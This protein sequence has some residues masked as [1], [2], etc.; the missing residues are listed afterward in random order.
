MV[1]EGQLTV[2]SVLLEENREIKVKCG[3]LEGQVLA[4]Q[5]EIRKL[6]LMLVKKIEQLDEMHSK[7]PV[8]HRVE[9]DESPK[10]EKQDQGVETVKTPSPNF[11][12]EAT[13]VKN[14]A[15][16]VG[17]VAQSKQLKSENETQKFK[18]ESELQSVRAKQAH[19]TKQQHQRS[20]VKSSTKSSVVSVK[21]E[22]SSFE[23]TRGSYQAPS[24]PQVQESQQMRGSLKAEA[25]I[26]KQSTDRKSN[27][28]D[29]VENEIGQEI[30]SR[31]EIIESNQE[32][33][34]SK[35]EVIGQPPINSLTDIKSTVL[36]TD[37]KQI[38]TKSCIVLDLMGEEEEASPTS[39]I[40]AF[41]E[42]TGLTKSDLASYLGSQ[43]PKAVSL[44]EKESHSGFALSINSTLQPKNLTAQSKS[45]SFSNQSVSAAVKNL[46]SQPFSI[47][48]KDRIAF[49]ESQVFNSSDLKISQRDPSPLFEPLNSGLSRVLPATSNPSS[50]LS[51]EPPLQSN[52][53]GKFINTTS[54]TNQLLTKIIGNA[55]PTMANSTSTTSIRYERDDTSSFLRQ[56]RAMISPTSNYTLEDSTERSLRKFNNTSY[57]F[58][59]D[60][61]GHSFTEPK[62][63]I[64][65]FQLENDLPS[66][67][68][69][70]SGLKSELLSESNRKGVEWELSLEQMKKATE[71]KE[72]E[73]AFSGLQ[74]KVA[75]NPK[76]KQIFKSIV[77][78]NNPQLSR[79]DIEDGNFEINFQ[80]FK[81]YVENFKNEHRRCG[82]NCPHLKRFYEKIGAV[83]LKYR[84]RA[85]LAI[86]I[87]DI[88]RLPKISP[89]KSTK[90][91]I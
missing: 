78:K 70:I 53:R 28:E 45:L 77:I 75:S 19:S 72:L 51:L 68:T 76:I 42:E 24:N 13:P 4:L 48:A 41:L 49:K 30:E 81:D 83:S 58:K 79:Q 3:E 38:Q 64:H 27:S 26:L 46:T 61:L 15:S 60:S 8:K 1:Y 21:T 44:Q 52:S 7:S 25:A 22:K 69:N 39:K 66:G 54:R 73:E 16:P 90:F 17:K 84:K 40:N 59:N 37:D 10:I 63:L 35:Q 86:R 34:E 18:V 82:E 43:E 62:S 87:T 89:K 55:K 31:Q 12:L 32:I 91:D 33:I 85:H 20:P 14:Q 47:A 23:K 50:I 80:I 74:E 11:K 2:H 5:E 71:E 88:E 56:R 29:F 36:S 9:S 6:Q 65:H 57:N 67:S